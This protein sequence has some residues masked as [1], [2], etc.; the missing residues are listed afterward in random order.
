MTEPITLPTRATEIMTADQPQLLRRQVETTRETMHKAHADWA[1]ARRS[2]DE[3][4]AR[5]NDYLYNADQCGDNAAEPRA[6]GAAGDADWIEWAD[7][8]ETTLGH[9][10]DGDQAGDGY[11]IDWIYEIWKQGI[12][13]DHAV[14]LIND[15]K[16]AH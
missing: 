5:L 11:S 1:A 7:D 4:R 3:A 16:N 14:G 13:V 6:A 12:S 8:L 10:L 2:W 9:D 15:S